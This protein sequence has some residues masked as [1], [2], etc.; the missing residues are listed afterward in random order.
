M[1]TK[2]KQEGKGDH[3]EPPTHKDLKKL[4]EKKWT[5]THLRICKTKCLWISCYICAIV[6]MRTYENFVKKSLKVAWIQR[7]IKYVASKSYRLTKNHRGTE[8]YY[9]E[10][11]PQMCE[12]PGR[13]YFLSE[14][15]LLKWTQHLTASGKNRKPSFL[16]MTNPGTATCKYKILSEPIW[17]CTF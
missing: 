16:Q 4:Y 1:L 7:D 8:N 2:H 12:I 17:K 9:G 11:G 15:Y 6:D 5:Q 14:Q 10:K 3:K 13:I